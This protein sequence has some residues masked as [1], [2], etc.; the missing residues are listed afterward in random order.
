MTSMSD[1]LAVYRCGWSSTDTEKICSKI[2]DEEYKKLSQK[3]KF[4][5]N[6]LDPTGVATAVATCKD[7][8]DDFECAKAIMQAASTFDVSG[9]LA[10]ASAFMHKTCETPE[11]DKKRKW[12]AVVAIT[13]ST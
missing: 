10:V 3:S 12:D 8:G 4:D 9:L 2:A 1:E 11:P 5:V 7:G 13:Q 6:R